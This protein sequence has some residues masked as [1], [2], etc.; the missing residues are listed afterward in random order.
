MSTEA[1]IALSEIPGLG[2]VR[3]QALAEVGI[4]DLEGLLALKARELAEVRGI[5]LWQAR[6]IREFLR[7][8][9]LL[10]GIDEDGSMV[11]VP[12]RTPAQQDALQR[13]VH[14]IEAQAEAEARVQA[15]VEALAQV[16]AEA[17]RRTNRGADGADEAAPRS[18]GR[19]KRSSPAAEEQAPPEHAAEH[20]QGANGDIPADETADVG[21]QDWGQAISAK[22]EQLPEVALAMIDAIRQAAVGKQLTRQL[23]RVLI[24]AGEFVSDTRPVSEECRREAH[25]V[26]CEVERLLA[27][28]MQRRAFSQ[29][30]QKDLAKRIRRKRKELEKL[31][32]GE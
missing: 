19:A 23:T 17:Q 3:L 31:L 32:V 21:K 25:E 20:A 22:R 26:L 29:D 14:A 16:V 13:S 12:P 11:L 2:P 27:Q 9:G 24:T 15:E 30:A 7:Q 6:K 10:V 5:G 8:R 18:R 4:N 28:T 1:R